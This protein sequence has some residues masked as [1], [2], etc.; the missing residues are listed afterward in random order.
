MNQS[1]TR[2]Q[3]S[4]DQYPSLVDTDFHLI[5]NNTLLNETN[6][7]LIE[8]DS[9]VIDGVE[10][11][12][13]ISLFTTYTKALENKPSTKPQEE[14]LINLDEGLENNIYK[15]EPNSKPNTQDSKDYHSE[16]NSGRPDYNNE[17]NLSINENNFTSRTELSPSNLENIAENNAPSLQRT[18]SSQSNFS[19]LFVLSQ[20]VNQE[21]TAL[22]KNHL[23]FYFF[24]LISYINLFFILRRYYSYLTAFPIL[25]TFAGLQIYKLFKSPLRNENYTIQKKKV[26]FLIIDWLSFISFF[27]GISLKYHFLVG[28]FFPL[29]AFCIIPLLNIAAYCLLKKS[30]TTPVRRSRYFIAKRLIFW[31][32]VLLISLKLDLWINISW[33]LILLF[34]L[35]VL[36]SFVV[37]SILPLIVFLI[38]IIL[39]FR[40]SRRFRGLPD[41]IQIFGFG[42]SFL[43]SLFSV[44]WFVTILGI[45]NVINN[46]RYKLLMIGLIFGM[47]HNGLLMLFT[48]LGWSQLHSFL[49]N[50]SLQELYTRTRQTEERFEDIIRFEIIDPEIPYLVMTSP[51]FHQILQE[52]IKSYNQEEIRSWKNQI[53]SLKAGKYLK[54]KPANTDAN[55]LDVISKEGIDQNNP[56]TQDR[57]SHSLSIKMSKHYIDASEPHCHSKLYYSFDDMDILDMITKRPARKL[58]E[59]DNLCYIC[60]SKVPNAIVMDCGHGGMCYECAIESWR[61]GNKCVMCRQEVVR[62]LKVNFYENINVSKPVHGTKKVVE[63]KL[64]KS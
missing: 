15:N 55:L 19:E 57:A 63:T 46:G 60:V 28:K 1:P 13:E 50:L 52:E 35:I 36:G 42:W 51:T 38:L 48:V 9:I 21:V 27:I 34:I 4:D 31:T 54:K 29:T 59:N 56:A 40:R 26:C 24:V 44:A 39:P 37:Y 18:N 58:N 25:C 47:I 3:V 6:K 45:E 22:L 61:K 14:T 49:N 7:R 17:I 41:T 23:E 2:L 12:R 10:S 53:F 32:Q 43:V 62:I 8:D 20:R 33:N 11:H 64:I 5:H 30:S 16:N